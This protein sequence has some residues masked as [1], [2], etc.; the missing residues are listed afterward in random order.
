MHKRAVERSAVDEDLQVRLE[1]LLTDAEIE[2]EVLI[3]LDD[4]CVASDLIRTLDQIRECHE[5]LFP[6][7][8][9]GLDPISADLTDSSPMKH[10]TKPPS[11]IG[12]KSIADIANDIEIAEDRIAIENKKEVDHMR[13]R[14]MQLQAEMDE[15]QTGLDEKK[16]VV[17]EKQQ[18]ARYNILSGHPVDDQ[19][20]VVR[21]MQSRARKPMSMPMSAA[22]A[23]LDQL[24]PARTAHSEHT[25]YV[26]HKSDMEILADTFAKAI[27]S[28][29]LPAP[30]PTVFTGNALEYVD[31][32]VSFR[33]LVEH[34]CIDDADKLTYLKRYV[35]GAAKECISGYF[36]LSS[37]NAYVQARQK[38]KDRFGS[39]HAITQAFRTK[40]ENWPKIRGGDHRNLI[41]FA[42][43]ISQC[44]AAL[45][46]IEDLSYLND[47]HQNA[48]MM[49]KLPDNL[50]DK[51]KA[52][53]VRYRKAHGRYPK[54][55]VFADF[56]RDEADIAA[57]P[58]MSSTSSSTKD[59]VSSGRV[60]RQEWKNKQSTALV[61]SNSKPAHPTCLAC[62]RNHDITECAT[63]AKYKHEDKQAFVRKHKLC[64]ACLKGAHQSKHCRQRATCKTCGKRHPTSMHFDSV[65]RDQSAQQNTTQSQSSDKPVK[66]TSCKVATKS[67]GLCSMVVPVCIESAGR[68][69]S[70]VLTYALLD[71]MSDTTFITESTA[72]K[73][74]AIG[75]ETTLTLTTMN[76]QDASVR[77]M[78][79]DNLVVRGI[80]N[81]E[82][83]VLSRAYSTKD[84]PMNIE[85]I[86]TPDV[87]RRWP[88][89]EH[90]AHM[91]PD[92]MNVEIGMLI[93]FDNASA[94]MP[95]ETVIGKREE[96]YA[97]RT[98]LGWCIVGKTG[99]VRAIDSKPICNRVS[100]APLAERSTVEPM[101]IA[102]LLQQDFNEKQYAHDKPKMSQDDVKFVE[103]LKAN[104]CQTNE[105]FYSMPLPFKE[106]PTMPDNKDMAL[107]RLH[108]LRNKLVNNEKFRQDYVAFMND[109][110]E[111][112]DAELAPK[113]GKIGEQWFIPHLGVY[114]PKKPD[115]IRVVFDCSAKYRDVCL[116][117]KLIAGPDMLNPMIGV[118]H[119][120]RLGSTAVMCDIQRM[121]H[122]FKVH[123]NDRNYL[124]FLWFRDD[125]FNEIAEY[126]MT[127]HLFG[128]ASSP[129]CATFGLRTLAA[130]K[131]DRHDDH[132]VKA[133]ELVR[134]NFYVDDGLFSF[135]D[136]V[137]AAAVVREA[138]NICAKGNIR[139]HKFVS[140]NKDLLA[141]IPSSERAENVK[142]LDLQSE[143][144]TLPMERALGVQWC[145]EDDIF[146]YKVKLKN[147]KSLNT[148][149][150]ISSIVASV[151]DPLG[152]LSPF[153]LTGK[154]I[155]QQMC[156][157]GATWDDPLDERLETSW[158][159]WKTELDALQTVRVP[160]C[161]LPTHMMKNDNMIVELHHF[162]DASTH[163][164]GQCTYLRVVDHGGNVHCALLSGKSRVA[165]LK[166]V[167]VP[168]LELQAAVLSAK[169][170]RIVASELNMPI[171]TEYFWTDSKVVLGYIQNSKR[172]FLVFVAN[173]VQQI[174]EYTTPSQWHYVN[175]SDN[176][177]DIASRGA[178]VSKLVDS[179][180]FDGPAFL[181]EN[182]LSPM[183]MNDH[184]E[185][186]PD[187]PEVKI[188]HQVSKSDSSS[189]RAKVVVDRV[190][191]FS[192]LDSAVLGICALQ[193]FARHKTLQNVPSPTVKDLECTKTMI[194]QCVQ[195]ASF[196]N[197]Y[198]QLKQ[199]VNV[200]ST[201]PL[202]KLDP[203]MDENG[204]IRVGGRLRSAELP[205]EEMH[206][207]ILPR[208]SHVSALIVKQCHEQ[209]A[210]QGRGLTVSRI[211]TSG[212]WIIGCSTVVRSF[213]H[214]C[215]TC[216]R[217]RR[218]TE[219]QKMADL[220]AER[221]V[222]S[223]P[224]TYVGCDVFG[225][226]VVKEGR[227]E[228]KRYGLIFTCM[229][230]RAIH[231]ELLDNM[232]TDAY[233]NALRCFISIRGP[234]R[235]VRT[236]RGSNFIGAANEFEKAM[237]EG[238]NQLKEFAMKNKIEFV[239][240]VP[241]ASHMGGVWE[242][243]IRTARN[244]LNSMFSLH[245]A[246]IDTSTLRTFCYEVMAIVNS[247]PLTSLYSD[248][249]DLSMPLTPNQILTMKS[250]VVKPPPGDFDEHDIY[251]RKR[252]RQVQG[253]AQTFW[254][255]WKNQYI[256]AL[257]ERS[258]WQ[259]TQPNVNV[260]D[261]V[262]L[263]DEQSHRNDW[264]LARVVATLPS[265][266]QLV[267]KVKVQLANA[268]LDSKGKRQTP[269]TTLDR[270]I[271]K[272]VVL[273][274]A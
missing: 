25:S 61:T 244:V 77:C 135:D 3:S 64:Y 101:H 141:M 146:T 233:I 80:E 62:E 174:L 138:V 116:N 87:A 78:I 208:N 114:H 214:K 159:A 125:S 195:Q 32:D 238:G 53:V 260:G 245:K 50:A 232:S 126:R 189:E 45:G 9:E 121:F 258:K 83:I 237:G 105:G 72:N 136:P 171:A 234:V 227:K 177:A 10:I 11:S 17:R 85:H 230:S 251:S 129:G 209:V 163:G 198:H 255:R 154:H 239:T 1:S 228:V 158:S 162:S 165:P 7:V 23:T 108:L 217:L 8:V 38:L 13:R 56:I 44:E 5:Y 184:Y 218:P 52:K 257:Q 247:R 271:Q 90:I 60:M 153:I 66:A 200:A 93:G 82:G 22:R 224:F 47:S 176:P 41:K 107:R 242:R 241:H 263:K 111:K 183:L 21:T 26:S 215:V 142:D 211:R 178:T 81:D 188:C 36:L 48:I 24:P 179:T 139:L 273:C 98:P 166:P 161:I 213:L 262:L 210:H 187:D 170:A 131:H 40:L 203:F 270:P 185:L 231:I 259:N 216:R 103:T 99:S 197:E 102:E 173:R 97:I 59:C 150:E 156:K 92:R 29:R 19:D 16:L 14:M 226:F 152:F 140:N 117:D 104:I 186:L 86:P 182:D 134:H 110:I 250:N 168:R 28:N 219:S 124:K 6:S 147:L 33:A 151:F 223:P 274:R 76:K 94:H 130:Q 91:I 265:K 123:E 46:Q 204:L 193:R 74:Q 15:L 221:T 229:A 122:M 145:V 236:D 143:N 172:K 181:W 240:N 180:W 84:I 191:R 43:F 96:P 201:S 120:F 35:A 49:G 206:P 205:Y 73:L 268:L 164:I 144:S 222:P 253:L 196:E 199:H 79:Y 157:D 51:W 54:F 118:L 30:E 95:L 190:E 63:L 70:S 272:L 68:P 269:P 65:P 42:D 12:A 194:L 27:R 57:D 220:P 225:P 71:S 39:D 37:P 109:I 202:A 34:S 119:R 106:R 192:N 18:E 69:G 148:K 254:V 67:T 113:M 264:P 169:M 55:A 207:V 267:R 88:H 256:H 20:D 89:L 167:T 115:K 31:W 58:V 175:T 149:R 261:I 132:S 212:Y 133:A 246:S 249:T 235:Q 2:Y 112:G 248:S 243:Q 100:T 4:Q 252:W 127:V 75:A 266:D 155:L 128:A 160:R 137:E